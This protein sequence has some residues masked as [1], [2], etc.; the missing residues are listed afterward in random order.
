[1]ILRTRHWP[2]SW[3]LGAMGAG[4]CESWHDHHFVRRRC[5][6]GIDVRDGF[7]LAVKA[8]WHGMTWRW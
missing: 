5:R 6:L 4:G 8:S 2:L 1:M 3:L 7:M